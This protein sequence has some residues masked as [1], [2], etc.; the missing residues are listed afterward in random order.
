LIPTPASPRNTILAANPF[1]ISPQRSQIA[2]T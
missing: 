1:E 2:L